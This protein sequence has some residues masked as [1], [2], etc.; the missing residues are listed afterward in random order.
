MI[1]RPFSTILASLMVI[2]RK[3]Y[4]GHFT[5]APPNPSARPVHVIPPENEM[6]QVK[7]NIP[8]PR[9]GPPPPA[10]PPPTSPPPSPPTTPEPS[11]ISDDELIAASSEPISTNTLQKLHHNT[12]SL[13]PVP[14]ANTPGPAEQ[15]TTFDPLKLHRIFGCRRFRNQQHVLA[16]SANAKLVKQGELPA[17]IGDYATI[18]KPD[19][20]KP[21]TKSRKYLDKVHMDI[22][23]GDCLG[24]G[25]YRYALLL[26]DV[27]TRYCWVYGMQALTSNEII[28]CFE[29]FVTAAGDVPKCFHSD[30]DK[31]LI[32]GKAL[33]WIQEHKSRV[34][35]SPSQRQSSNG[36][37]ER[38]WQT[39]IRMARAYITEK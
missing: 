9:S 28:S 16:A 34:I 5:S 37:V 19:K 3:K 32:G 25:G 10:T 8:T 39:L 17:T 29:Q 1:S 15:R 12:D 33:R 4:F 35:A 18:N 20:G 26:V 36:L 7:F 2:G 22:V 13:P 30:F 14:P 27:A 23:F 11:V 31:K 24:L 21:L 6:H 38:T